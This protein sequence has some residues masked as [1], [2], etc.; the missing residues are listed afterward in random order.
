MSVSIIGLQLTDNFQYNAI[1]HLAI[2]LT[3]AVAG[4]LYIYS[5]RRLRGFI[6]S[7]IPKSTVV[8]SVKSST[9]YGGGIKVSVTSPSRGQTNSRNPML[10]GA[11]QDEDS[12]RMNDIPKNVTSEISAQDANCSSST[13]VRLKYA[14][15]KSQQRLSTVRTE[16]TPSRTSKVR[17]QR[18]QQSLEIMNRL[19]KLSMIFTIIAPVVAVSFF[20]YGMYQL[21][22]NIKYSEQWQSERRDYHAD[23]DFGM[24]IGTI[25]NGYFLLYISRWKS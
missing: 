7:T 1:K 14:E 2:G 12:Q 22:K 6:A 20:V 21:E 19:N 5:L 15:R 23:V 11:F 17:S 13:T 10:N 24:W 9:Y 16:I 18:I 3:I 8:S 25:A 4:S